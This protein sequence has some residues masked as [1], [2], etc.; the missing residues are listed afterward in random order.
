MPTTITLPA[1]ADSSDPVSAAA[2]HLYLAERHLKAL[3]EAFLVLDPS[4]SI[5]IKFAASEAVANEVFSKMKQIKEVSNE[6]YK[7]N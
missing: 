6:Y 5:G 2:W 1:V 4:F 3:K 7:S